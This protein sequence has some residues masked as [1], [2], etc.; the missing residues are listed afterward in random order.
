MR[1]TMIAAGTVLVLGLAL[2]GCG[3]ND[4]GEPP[5]NNPPAPAPGA[6]ELNLSGRVYRVDGR[7]G[8]GFLDV[9]TFTPFPAG[10]TRTVSWWRGGT[11][12]VANGQLSFTVATPTSLRHV[13]D[14][15]WFPGGDYVTFDPPAAQAAELAWLSTQAPGGT[16]SRG[17]MSL[18][19]FSMSI[20]GSS[21]SGELVVR[22]HIY[23]D[24]DVVVSLAQDWT[25]TWTDYDDAGVTFNATEIARAFTL[26]LRQGWN[27]LYLRQVSTGTLSEIAANPTSINATVT[28]TLTVSVVDPGRQLRWML[29]WDDYSE[30]LEL[31]RSAPP[32]RLGAPPFGT[33]R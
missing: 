4:N 15:L 28:S 16:H 17:S 25:R 22:Q 6:A 31:F 29:A 9:P 14:E 5:V 18:E 20:S 1:K 10:Q 30:T 19:Y 26:I 2:A 21:L 12:T 11:G 7:N 27:A 33:R 24:R 8:G 32:G 23:V 3:S 13:E